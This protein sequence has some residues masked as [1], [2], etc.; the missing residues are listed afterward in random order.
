[1]PPTA[2][3]AC[4][5]SGRGRRQP[6]PAAGPLTRPD[7]RR[8]KQVSA[9]TPAGLSA[10]APCDVC[11]NLRGGAER[12][13]IPRPPMASHGLHTPHGSA[14]NLTRLYIRPPR[15]SARQRGAG[16]SWQG[17]AT[18]QPTVCGLAGSL[19]LGVA[20]LKQWRGARAEAQVIAALQRRSKRRGPGC[21]A[22]PSL[23]LP[24]FRCH[25]SRMESAVGARHRLW[26]GLSKLGTFR[27]PGT[28]GQR[29]SPQQC[30]VRP[31]VADGHVERCGIAIRACGSR[32]LC[33]RGI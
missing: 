21:P 16:P 14:L 20:V 24:L 33:I 13:S 22:T 9:T 18:A 11:T 29:H 3:D 2:P 19:S 1:M 26:H 28:R 10:A 32:S 7:R 4:S 6:P 15:P 23:V 31:S 25:C 8:S 27:M 30:N 5:C 12:R 17:A